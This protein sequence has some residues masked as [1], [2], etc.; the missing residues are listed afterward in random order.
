[1]PPEAETRKIE[2]PNE[3]SN[4][5]LAAQDAP[6]SPAGSSAPQA[7]LTPAGGTPSALA[8]REGRLGEAET[9]EEQGDR[10]LDRLPNRIDLKDGAT[11]DDL[12]ENLQQI[13]A[14]A[15]DIVSILQAMKEAGALEAEL[16]VL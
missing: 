6:S 8:V 13:G 9:E 1:M 7:A 15:R 10:R 12:V 3:R 2:R 4:G 16:E 5:A 11:V 14:T